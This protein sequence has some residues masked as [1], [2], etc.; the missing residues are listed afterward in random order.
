MRGRLNWIPAIARRNQTV[1]RRTNPTLP[2]K[3]VVPVRRLWDFAVR[4][5]A[6]DGQEFTN[7]DTLDGDVRAIPGVRSAVL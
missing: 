4:S 2:C 5:Y 6:D 7:G 3:A 1:A